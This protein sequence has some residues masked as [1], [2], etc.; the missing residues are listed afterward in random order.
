M[1]TAAIFV[2]GVAIYLIE[3]DVLVISDFP[4]TETS[5][6]RQVALIEHAKKII[7]SSVAKIFLVGL[8]GFVAWMS[9]KP[10]LYD[11]F[12]LD[13]RFMAQQLANS[14]YPEFKEAAKFVQQ[15]DYYQARQVSSKL[16]LSNLQNAD[17]A[18]QYA[19]ILI[20]GD[21]I[22]TSKQVLYPIFE[23][24]HL[25]DRAAAAYLLGLAFLKEENYQAAKYWLARVPQK[26]P[27]YY[28][29]KEII[30]RLEA[31]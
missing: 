31:V 22:E 15:G 23:S 7:R 1:Q 9:W 26:S 4:T 13:N 8:V 2:K 29:A 28:Q 25:K 20:A 5:E 10:T 24:N 30:S 18:K 16:V 3:M 14:P 6:P 17:I 19:A 12:K 21:C 27:E 11:Q